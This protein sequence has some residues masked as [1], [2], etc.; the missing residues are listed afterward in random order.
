M[1]KSYAYLDGKLLNNGEIIHSNN[2]SY[3]YGDGLFE[4]IRIMNGAPLNVSNH[5][6]RL[7]EGAQ[8]LKMRLPSYLNAT[9]FEEKIKELIEKSGIRKGGKCKISID[10]NAGGAYLP[11]NSEVSYLIEVFPYEHNL[12]ELNQK[13][14]EIDIYTDIRKTKNMLSGYKTK[15][16][17]LYIMA[18]IQA[19]ENGL[20]DMLICNERGGI[21]ESSNS[22]LFLV[23][24]GVLYTPGLDEGCLAGTMRMQVI[25]LAIK[26]GMK[27]Y[28]SQILPQNLLAAD[29]IFLTNAVRGVTWVGGYRTKRYF[30]VVARRIQSYLNDH[31][32]GQQP[33]YATGN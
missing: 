28:E 6:Q 18:A 20:Q 12:F 31:W 7:E 21:L 15:N 8:A 16:C 30:N 9:F 1:D 14:I 24:N 10:R 22:N 3:S 29:E 5:F 26:H 27:V 17:L 25:N 32:G 19:R 4:S 2:R 11:E 23:S 33:S 13:G